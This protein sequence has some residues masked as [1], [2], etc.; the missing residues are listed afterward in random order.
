MFVLILLLRGWD[1]V[2]FL[3]LLFQVPSLA[4]ALLDAAHVTKHNDQKVL[5]QKVSS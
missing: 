1:K 4:W 2:L 5:F 3:S